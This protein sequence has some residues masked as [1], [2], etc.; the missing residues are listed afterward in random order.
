MAARYERKVFKDLIRDAIYEA[1]VDGELNPGDRIIEAEWAEKLGSSQAPVR[2][3]IR[4]L[5]GRGVVES[6]PFK[7][8]VVRKVGKEEL[9]EIHEIRAGLEAVAL[10]KVIRV[11]TDDEIKAVKKILTEMK[12]AAKAGEEQTFLKK[13]VEFHETIVDIAD[14][15]DLKKMWDMCNIRLWTAYST[16]YSKKDMIEL[17]DNH[18]VIFKKIEARDPSEIFETI[19]SH[20]SV[21]SDSLDEEKDQ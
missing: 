3:A 13:D 16:K 20:F 9:G 19:F 4:D 10:S 1:I 11:I 12:S 15:P 5:E 2:E 6:E 18:E 7:G 8:A 17:A 21:I 14:S